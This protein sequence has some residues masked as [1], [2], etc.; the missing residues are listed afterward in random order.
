[1]TLL[2]IC[3]PTR[4]RQIYAMSAVRELLTSQR[5]DFEVVLADNSDDAAPL[6][7]FAKEYADPRLKL[8]PP[9]DEV[10]SMRANWERIVPETSGEWISYIGD[11]DYLDPELCE[12]I[13]VSKKSVPNMDALTW[14]R[15]Y[16]VWPEART[17]PEVTK[18]P[19]GSHLIGIKKEDMIRKLFFWEDASDRPKCP[20]GVYHGAVKRTV[21]ED[22]RTTFSG[23]YFSHQIVDYDNI[24]RTLMVA[25][26]FVYFERPMSVFG[27]CKASNTMG[28]RDAKAAKTVTEIFRREMDGTIEAS[29]FPFPIELGITA[30]IGHVIESFK[31]EQGI[32]INAW[33]DN[34][35]KACAR[36]C[37]SQHDRKLFEAQKDG[38]RKA[39]IE[40]KGKDALSAF[41]PKYKYRPDIPP[42]IGFNDNELSLDMGIGDAASAAEFYGILDTM[43]FPVHLLEGRLS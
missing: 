21:L 43:M 38:Y 19:N 2:S 13:R 22:I 34:F 27:A 3:I 5:Q 20:F 26:S 42:F 30:Q 25:S 12:V 23:Q 41:D 16:F 8:L 35:I 28:L 7:Q 4:N 37:E 9:Q 36:N 11:D 10:L 18:M 33:E 39:I 29:N 31:Q 6:A 17:A 15:L 14:G 40:W 1:M 32:E 24:C